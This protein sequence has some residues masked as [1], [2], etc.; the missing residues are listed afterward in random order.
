MIA[1]DNKLPFLFSFLSSCQRF[2]TAVDNEKGG[3]R[4]ESK[5]PFDTLFFSLILFSFVEMEPKKEIKFTMKKIEFWTRFIICSGFSG[6]GR[7]ITGSGWGSRSPIAPHNGNPW[8]G[9]NRQK[10]MI[11][12]NG[13]RVGRFC[14]QVCVC[15]CVS[16]SNI[17]GVEE[18]KEEEIKRQKIELG[19]KRTHTHITT[20]TQHTRTHAHTHGHLA[21]GYRTGKTRLTSL[22]SFPFNLITSDE[23][24]ENE[25]FKQNVK[26]TNRMKKDRKE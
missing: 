24:E 5:F 22:F 8:T 11:E 13:K 1:Q 21:N 18:R 12:C 2:V 14:R 23:R 26:K 16:C 6:R 17:F 4:R 19:A 15:V 10:W 7:R 20:H 3:N 25:K 9:K